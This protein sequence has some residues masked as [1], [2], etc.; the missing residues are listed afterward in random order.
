MRGGT[1]LVASLLLTTATSVAGTTDAPVAASPGS[2]DG[3]RIQTECPTFTW[4][5]VDHATA[6]ELVIYRLAAEGG[7]SAPVLRKRFPYPVDGWTPGVDECLEAGVRYAWSIRGF[8]DDKATNW[9]IPTLFE[10]VAAT[11]QKSVEEAMAIVRRYLENESIRAETA[12]EPLRDKTQKYEP[13]AMVAGERSKAATGDN[14]D[15]G[16]VVD[17]ALVETKADPPCYPAEDDPDDTHRFINCDNGTVLDTVSGLLWMEWAN[18]RSCIPPV[19]PCP[20]EDGQRTWFQAV[21]FAANLRHGTCGLADRS[22]KGDWRLPSKGEWETILDHEC[23]TSPKIAGKLGFCYA[24]QNNAWALEVESGLGTSY[25]W[26]STSDPDG[27]HKAFEASMSG[28]ALIPF[29]KGESNNTYV[30]AVRGPE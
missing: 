23:V 10:V 12:A 22:Q 24:S 16:I 7:Q 30:W 26:S 27:V 18:C 20:V 3:A 1:S 25:Y 17:G 15:G 14:A 19:V 11:D 21:R 13:P 28:G 5:E 29:T 2:P 9:S 6:Y 4:S 8:A